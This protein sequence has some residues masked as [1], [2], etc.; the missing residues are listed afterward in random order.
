MTRLRNVHPG[1]VLAEEFLK[2]MGISAYRLAKDR[3]P[4]DAPL[5][6]NQGEA[7]R[8]SGHGPSP[9][10]VLRH[11]GPVLARASGRLRPRGGAGSDRRRVEQDRGGSLLTNG[12]ARTSSA[13][14]LAGR[15]DV[16]LQE[17]TG[18][19]GESQHEGNLAGRSGLQGS[20]ESSVSWLSRTDWCSLTCRSSADRS[21]KHREIPRA[22]PQVFRPAMGRF[23]FGALP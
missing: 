5:A 12:L 1:E 18:Q 13:R 17:S 10:H 23:P 2:P 11:I 7:A 8:D 4:A 6:D 20:A 21:G 16:R 9:V 22:S 15:D 19:Q 14:R 3:Y